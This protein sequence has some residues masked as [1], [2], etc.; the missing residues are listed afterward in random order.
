MRGFERAMSAKRNPKYMLNFFV[1][2]FFFVILVLLHFD[3]DEDDYDCV[4]FPFFRSLCHSISLTYVSVCMCANRS[5]FA[6]YKILFELVSIDDVPNIFDYDQI[7]LKRMNHWEMALS[8]RSWWN[9]DNDDVK[10]TRINPMSINRRINR[11]VWWFLLLLISLTWRIYVRIMRCR[12]KCGSFWTEKKITVNVSKKRSNDRWIPIF[13][14]RKKQNGMVTQNSC[15]I[16]CGNGE[17]LW[18]LHFIR[19]W[20]YFF[21]SLSLS[22]LRSLTFILCEFVCPK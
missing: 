17:K 16:Y 2:F 12:Q 9:D 11:V 7:L 10:T 8:K 6:V 22:R 1:F 13:L 3:S 15:K 20:I 21:M 18:L 19:K 14:A 4:L 5:Q